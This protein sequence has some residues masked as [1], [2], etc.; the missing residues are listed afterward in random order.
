MDGDWSR[1][2][3][4]VQAARNGMGLS[5]VGLGELAGVKRTAI[6]TIERGH[7]FLR[8]TSTLRDVEHALGWGRGS[9]E[10]ILAGGDPL[11]PGEPGELDSNGRLRSGAYG[12]LPLRVTHALTEGTTLDTTIVPLTPNAEMVV[13]VKGKPSATPEQLRLAL[14][15]W[16]EQGGYLAR[17]ARLADTPQRNTSES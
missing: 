11:A 8:V 7:T 12:G 2:G 6:Q 13:V 16:E 14:L 5:Q 17:L 9:I 15:A 10:L 3:K 4:A 1:L